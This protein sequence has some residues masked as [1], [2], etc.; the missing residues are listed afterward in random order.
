MHLPR[1]IMI[2]FFTLFMQIWNAEW[3]RAQ[4]TSKIDWLQGYV[5]ATGRGYAKKTG[6]PMDI[7]NAVD[8]AKIE[9][10]SELLETIK[11]VKIDSQTAVSDLLVEKTEK[12]AR[13]QGLLHN[14]ILVGE[15]QIKDEGLFV[16]AVV[17]MR[18]CLHNNGVGCKTVQSLTSVLPKLSS[19]KSHQAAS[20]DL[21][22]DLTS[23]QEILARI[24]YDTT[25]PLNLVIINIGGKPFNSGSNDFAIGFESGKGQNCSIYTPEKIDPVVRR[26]RGTAEV[27]L[28]ASDAEKK[29]GTNVLKV[30]AKSIS[31]E[32][33]IILDKKD[34]YLINLINNQAKQEL[35]R[36]AKFGIAVN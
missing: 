18:V 5:T 23:T 26:D 3:C 6:S 22:P 9:A 25:K 21:L 27:F 33:Y 32:N 31:P 11:G 2:I 28:N 24:S 7:D 35:F 12:S 34:A 16:V 4:N 36:N 13:V 30:S 15:P 10:Q 1:I 14:S 29:Y 17:E 8:A 19:T 20:C